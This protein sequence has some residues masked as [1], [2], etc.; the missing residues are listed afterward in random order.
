MHA[1]FTERTVSS[2]SYMAHSGQRVEVRKNLKHINMFTIRA[3]D[4][5]E[6]DAFPHELSECSPDLRLLIARM[7]IL[8]HVR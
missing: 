8:G 6:G 3:E 4:E 2:P 1:K 5:W 7:R